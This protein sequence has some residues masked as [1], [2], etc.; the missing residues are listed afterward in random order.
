MKLSTF[1]PLRMGDFSRVEIVIRK[2]KTK[3]FTHK[4]TRREDIDTPEYFDGTIRLLLPK[5][6]IIAKMTG[7]N[8]HEALK[9]GFD[10]LVFEIEKYK[11]MNFKNDS[12]FSNRQTIRRGMYEK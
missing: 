1:I 7:K 8:V 9:D 10:E 5:K 11:G 3:S 12:D 4:R 2:H 6:D